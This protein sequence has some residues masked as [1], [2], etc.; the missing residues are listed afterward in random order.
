ML[1]FLWSVSD[2]PGDNT[3]IYLGFRVLGFRVRGS[4]SYTSGDVACTG[5]SKTEL[6][7]ERERERERTDLELDGDA[8]TGNS[9]PARTPRPSTPALVVGTGKRK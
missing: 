9:V 8:A 4:R 6:E 2:A 7:G 1:I 5:G 3:Q